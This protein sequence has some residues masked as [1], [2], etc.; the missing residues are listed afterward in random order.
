VRLVRELLVAD[1]EPDVAQ[2]DFT[3]RA[4]RLLGVVTEGL[5]LRAGAL[6][7]RN[8]SSGQ[9][10]CIASTLP[11]PG[12]T[13]LL[14]PGS[15]TVGLVR[16]AAEERRGFLAR[17]TGEEPLL[18]ALRERDSGIEAVAVLPL[19]DRSP[20]GV[21]VLAGGASALAAD[22]IRTL[23]PALRLLALL[24]SPVREGAPAD[25]AV[26]RDLEAARAESARQAAEVTRLQAR[27]AE[28]EAR[29]GS[30]SAESSAARATR[31]LDET[32]A[33]AHAVEAM[34]APEGP[35][36]LVVVD[37]ARFWESYAVP[38]HALVVVAPGD[39]VAAQ[40]HALHPSRVIVNL[41]SPHALATLSTLESGGAVRVWGVVADT[42]N[43]RVIGLG[44]V[45]AV[46][47][48][49]PETLVVAVERH[50]PRGA[51]VF[52][53]GRDADM[54]MKTRQALSKLGF[55]VSMARDAKQIDELFEMVRPQVVIVDLGLPLRAGYELVMRAASIAP[56]PSIVLI[57]AE[58]DAVAPLS[59]KLA[60]RLAAGRGMGAKQ[61]LVDLAAQKL[62]ALAHRPKVAHAASAA[63][64]SASAV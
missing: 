13:M 28:L 15:R 25:P 56:P 2:A 47:Q 40:V 50:G 18:N 45:D 35:P 17:G 10:D 53:A 55:S 8:V 30:G 48:P 26:Q 59:E 16:R 54:L 58:N 38:N 62:K 23:T 9:L 63:A 22:T 51:R 31:A 7:L 19:V 49:T 6:V 20:V 3:G 64:G 1:A 44:P 11:E 43:E 37:T 41:V 12:R 52:A 5:S 24:V 21:L 34:A 57:P 46:L 39:G 32:S 60:E 61:W 36:L 4:L 14:E 33:T 29:L 42:T 27:V